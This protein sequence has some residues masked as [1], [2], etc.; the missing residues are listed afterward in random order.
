[1]FGHV[2]R[3]ALIARINRK[4][5]HDDDRMLRTTRTKR[6]HAE[7]GEHYIVSATG[8]IVATNVDVENLG[9]EL[10]VLRPHVQL[11]T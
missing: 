8:G 3:K 11:A 5:A 9:R 4:L 6:A 2:S 7:L 1:M 10:G